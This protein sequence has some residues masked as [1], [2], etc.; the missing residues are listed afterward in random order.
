MKITALLAIWLL[1]ALLLVSFT[2]VVQAETELAQLGINPL[3]GPEL[4][5]N[6]DFREMIKETFAD[7]KKGFEKA[8]ASDLF[9]D[10]VK[11]A[12]QPDIREIDVN[13]GKKLQWMI[14]KKGAVV[15]V[16]R[17]VVWIGK[18]PFAAFLLN[19]DKTGVRYPFVIS[20]K[21]GN[22]SLALPMPIPVKELAPNDLPFCEA[23]ISPIFLATG[24]DV[25]V[26]A[27]QSADPDGTVM[28]M[29]VQV[30]DAS[31]TVLSKNIIDKP[32][33]IERL[34]MTQA[35]DYLIR[36][37]VTDDKGTESYSPGCPETKVAVT[38]PGSPETKVT[39]TTP[40]EAPV[41]KGASGNFVADMAIMHRHDLAYLPLRIGYD[42]AL[43][44]SFSIL[45]MVG[46]APVIDGNDDDDSIMADVTANFHRQ[47]LFFGAG[48]GTWHSS[49]DDRLDA[50]LN[51][52]YRVYGDVGQFNISVFI[53]GRAAFDQLD[54]L[55]D[56]GRLGAGLRFQF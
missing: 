40:E 17:D 5:S 8:G 47:R 36:V 18:E 19:V 48:I 22:V 16:I 10:F 55:N 31:N 20:A 27:S 46:V 43:S 54:E 53:E 45:G 25:T 34:T 4:K 30:E 42:Y 39:V 13:P 44:G 1:A 12:E 41:K 38:T 21:S 11:Q 51:A 33:F 56:Y 49:M 32:P 9:E 24:E 23:D 28:S 2:G 52:G 15:E 14:F 37:S 29:L 7:L 50:I 35:G 26:D 3:Y 6:D